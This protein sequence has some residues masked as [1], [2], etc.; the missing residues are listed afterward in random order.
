MDLCKILLICLPW[1]PANGHLDWPQTGTAETYRVKIDKVFAV[2]DRVRDIY[3]I[4]QKV[5][6]IALAE[7]KIVY[8]SEPDQTAQ[9]Y[10]LAATVPD[11]YGL[12]KGIRAAMRLG[13]WNNRTACVI[14]GEIFD[15]RH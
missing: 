8:I 14:S 1:L 12:P 7:N 15:A 2:S 3:P 13:F 9:K 11:S 6:P 4:L 10:H 5:Y